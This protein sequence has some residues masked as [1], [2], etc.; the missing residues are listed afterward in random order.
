M[1]DKAGYDSTGLMCDEDYGPGAEPVLPPF[2]G[3]GIGWAIGL[4]LALVFVAVI[5]WTTPS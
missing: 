5:L 1:C 2:V 4:V 3:G